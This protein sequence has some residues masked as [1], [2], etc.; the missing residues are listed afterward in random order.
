MVRSE[1]RI[2]TEWSSRRLHQICTHF[3]R[4][5]AAVHTPFRGHIVFPFGSCRLEARGDLLVMT[6]EAD[7]ASVLTRLEDVLARQLE[8]FA[9]GHPPETFWTGLEGLKF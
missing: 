5:T 8:R 7:E 6:V 2:T 4:E 3:A 1:R 9:L